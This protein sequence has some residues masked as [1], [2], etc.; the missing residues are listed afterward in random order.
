MH[1]NISSEHSTVEFAS[2]HCVLNVTKHRG[3]EGKTPLSS[4]VD[5]TKAPEIQV[6]STSHLVIY[7][8]SQYLSLLHTDIFKLA[9]GLH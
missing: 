4:T 8:Q 1:L 5:G 2:L 6:S 7:I 3:N 9:A